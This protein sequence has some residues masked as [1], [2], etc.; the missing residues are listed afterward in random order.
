MRIEQISRTTRL[1][2]EAV[3]SRWS[4]RQ[5]SGDGRW[6]LALH[7]TSW[8]RL[9][10]GQTRWL[11][12][13]HA[14]EAM[15]RAA[16]ADPR[17][18]ERWHRPYISTHF[19]AAARRRIVNAHYDFVMRR[20]PAWLA[21]RLVLGGGARLT[22]LRLEDAADVHLHLRKPSRADAGEL[23]LLLLSDD[24]DVLASCILTFD[25]RDSITIGALRGAGPHAPF[26]AT[27]E[28]IRGSHGLHP[29]DLLMSLV[30]ELAALH[31]LKRIRAVTAAACV[32]QSGADAD[33][34]DVEAAASGDAFWEAQGGVSAGAGCHALPLS[35]IP[36]PCA[37]GP[38]SRR[39]RQQHSEAFRRKAAEVFAAALR[40]ST[41]AQPAAAETAVPREGVPTPA[42]RF[43]GGEKHPAAAASLLAAGP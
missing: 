36:A 33:G 34:A 11:H 27:R 17:L 4:L 16:Q 21:E 25:R 2:M 19:S 13:L 1:W 37:E 7:M 29:K 31:G 38:R 28:F 26:E 30:R 23:S 6:Q 14:R 22:T 41:G 8:L 40:R 32:G 5:A 20:F 18:Y 10:V 12:S 3:R 24:K 39:E 43:R 35:L 15:W 42:Q 9:C